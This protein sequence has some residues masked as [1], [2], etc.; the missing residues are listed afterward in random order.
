MS[1][2]VRNE[3]F[4]GAPGHP[5]LSE[6]AKAFA[7]PEF[8]LPTDANVGIACSGGPDSVALLCGMAEL[9]WLGLKQA[10]WILHYMH[11]NENPDH[12]ANYYCENIE[13]EIG[14]RGE[15]YRC[16][17]FEDEVAVKESQQ[18]SARRM[19]YRFFREEC[20]RA[21]LTHLLM[22]HTLDDQAETVL[23]HMT[24]GHWLGGLSGIPPR[25]KL[26]WNEEDGNGAT[27]ILRPLLGI[28]RSLTRDYAIQSHT[29]YWQFEGPAGERPADGGCYQRGYEHWFLLDDPSNDDPNDR[30]YQFRHHVIPL[31]EKIN[32]KVKE[33]IGILASQV[34]IATSRRRAE[35]EPKVPAPQVHKRGEWDQSTHWSIRF[36]R[37]FLND[38]LDF[39]DACLAVRIAIEYLGG[40]TR[41]ISRERCAMVAEASRAEGQTSTTSLLK[42]IQFRV[43]KREVVVIGLA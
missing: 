39:N 11:G 33:N 24:N 17:Y 27:T 42:G 30:R 31:L 18:M 12:H 7:K 15:L 21:K 4:K 9:K 32:P 10:P 38:E 34:T 16:Y 37:S 13:F 5:F 1:G 20:G 41:R 26:A 23:M 28:P 3:M 14:A 40:E 22:G 8:R 36:R 29:P 25:R 2:Y 35:I 6:L 19:R 43:T